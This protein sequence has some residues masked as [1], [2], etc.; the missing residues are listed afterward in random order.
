[1]AAPTLVAASGQQTD[2]GGAW[3][4]VFPDSVGAIGNVFILQILQDGGTNGAVALTSSNFVNK[5]DGT[6]GWTS[7]GTFA[8]G[9][10]TEARQH[11]WIGRAT[12][13]T[14]AQAPGATGTNSTSED[15]YIRFYE[16][17]D[18]ST[19][20]TLA[21][22][23]ENG[24]AG[25]T[26]NSTGT[27]AT[28]SDASVQTLGTDRLAVNFVAVNDDNAIAQFSGQSGGTWTETAEYAEPSGTDGAIQL[29]RAAMASAG[30]IDGG[31][32]SITDSDA[33]GV[34][35]FALI[36]T[37]ADGPTATGA[38]ALPAA[39]IA[40]T[41]VTT[42]T[43]TG[44]VALPAVTVAGTG[45][46]PYMGTGALTLPAVTVDGD[47][48]ET[49][50]STGA[51]DLAA[52]TVAGTGVES[53]EAT[54][55]LDL[56]AVVIDGTGEHSFTPTGTGA[57]TLPGIV[58]DGTGTETFTA[59]G[60]VELAPVVIDGTG[61]APYTGTGA[62]ALPAVT[63]SGTGVETFTSTG[64]VTLEPVVVAG[65]GAHAVGPEA[66]G[67]VTLTAPTLDGTGV[68]TYTGTGALVLGA[69]TIDGTGI[70]QPSGT[71]ALDLA[72]IVIAG[73]GE[74]DVVPEPVVVPGG[75]R[76]RPP[77]APPLIT[78]YGALT[79]ASAS[80]SGQGTHSDN[81]FRFLMDPEL[82]LAGVL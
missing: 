2:A 12:S 26:V 5:L 48:E 60:A 58:I 4:E 47:G 80:L 39:T 3:G 45:T 82:V 38:L 64:A 43:S 44:A 75:R 30:T 17:Q 20:T 70:L 9:G 65:D 24:S 51:L 37:T 57:L 62:L 35:G 6:A 10:S 34:V 66:T 46:A 67:A 53:F 31:T 7:I 54:G 61:T 50:T 42:Y 77:Q 23:I 59:T 55:A 16:F 40:G 68:V 81:D 69:P 56:P 1:M 11:L 28:A 25:A 74:T 27:S 76:R 18:V 32:A 79:L 63:A 78:G 33:W 73:T 29:Q 71:G 15:L 19:G 52:V 49:F 41:G 21:T 13:T 22:V 8:V 72:G 14:A 36:G